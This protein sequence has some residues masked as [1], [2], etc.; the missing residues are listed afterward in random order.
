MGHRHGD[1]RDHVARLGGYDGGSENLVR[2]FFH[3]HA[4]EAFRLPIENGSI[5]AVQ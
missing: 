1:L 5:H 3:V 4:S 2:A